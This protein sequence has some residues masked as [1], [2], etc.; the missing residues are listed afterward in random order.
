EVNRR[1]RDVHG[2]RHLAR[3][4]FRG[5]YRGRGDEKSH[6]QDGQDERGARDCVERRRSGHGTLL[7]VVTLSATMPR[8][9]NG[10]RSKRDYPQTS[11]VVN[12]RS[13]LALLGGTPKSSSTIEPHRRSFVAGWICRIL[14]G[15]E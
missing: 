2:P 7:C 1:E 8:P 3:G 15:Q 11:G 13:A 14:R 5:G 10:A 12:A 6:E 4:R 9:T